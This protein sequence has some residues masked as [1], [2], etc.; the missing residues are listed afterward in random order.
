MLG[1]C[2]VITLS[3][4]A[5]RIACVIVPFSPYSR[6]RVVPGACREHGS[7]DS[8]GLRIF[9]GRRLRFAGYNNVRKT[10]TKSARWGPRKPD[11]AT[12]TSTTIAAA[13]CVKSYSPCKKSDMSVC[14]HRN[15]TC[16]STFSSSLYSGG[17]SAS[18]GNPKYL[19][20]AFPCPSN[21]RPR[22][23]YSS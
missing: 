10:H 8:A 18:I 22:W 1:G 17:C 7:R 4:C 2:L 15:R 12:S 13:L 11:L 14:W 19:A 5:I 21:V 6:T 20:F 16:P 23:S 3:Q 9:P